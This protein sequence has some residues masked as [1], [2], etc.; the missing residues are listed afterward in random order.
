M[1]NEQNQPSWPAP[2][3]PQFQPGP[4]YPSSGP[5]YQQSG[6]TF[7]PSAPYSGPPQQGRPPSYSG[8]YPQPNPG[9]RSPKRRSGLAGV[10][11]IA[12]LAAGVG[13]GSGFVA[14]RYLE[15]GASEAVT[16]T[17]S[18]TPTTETTEPASGGQQTTV[19]QADPTNPDWSAVADVASDSVV[20]IQV[21][22]GGSGSQGSGVVIDGAGHIV[23]NNHVVASAASGGQITVLLG[24][25]AYQAEAVGFDPSTDLAVIKLTDPPSDLSV[26][27]YGDSKAVQVGDPVMAIGNPL[28]LADTVT[29]GIVS[30]LNRPVTTRA[31]TNEPVNQPSRDNRVVTAAIQTNAAI[32]PGNSGGALVNAAGELIGITSSIASLPAAGQEQAG[33]IGI[34]FAIGADQ[35]QYVVEQLIATGTAQHPQLGVS[36]SDVQDYG[37]LGAEVVEVVPGSPA[38]AAGLQVGDRVTSVDGQPVSSTESLVA[39]VRAGRVGEEM[40]LT[41]LRGGQEMTVPVTPIAAPR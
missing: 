32:N 7:Q 24:N 37:P 41:I 1:S 31:V 15:P 19:V 14:S 29:T 23:T 35:V 33:N 20:A 8:G 39:L 18:P 36:A 22:G 30:A 16:S 11:A 25:T 40:E 34:G 12:T 2:Q 28:G 4:S 38:E 21:A 13:G 27:G 9:A 26:M 3:R 5:S 10:L 17:Q 6:P